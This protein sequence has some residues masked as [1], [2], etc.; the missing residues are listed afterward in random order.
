MNGPHLHL[1]INHAP[2]IAA[3]LGSALLLLGLLRRS[4]EITNV[5]LGVIFLAALAAIPTYL[6]GQPAADIVGNIDGVSSAAIEKHE[7]AAGQALAVISLA[8]VAALVA[9]L[10]DWRRKRVPG[11]LLVFVLVLG[12]AG[13][14]LLGLAANLGGLIRHTEIAGTVASSSK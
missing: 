9:L 13:V 12:L 6:T 3:P 11:W 4:R 10:L 1:L 14:V 8:G 2:V 5:G 7:D